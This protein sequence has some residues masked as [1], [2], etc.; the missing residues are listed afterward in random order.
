MIVYGT[1]GAGKA[2][3]ASLPA[4]QINAGTAHWDGAQW[5]PPASE[6]VMPFAKAEPKQAFLKVGIYGPQ[7]SGKTFT[8]LLMAEGIAKKEK[9]RIAYV[10]TERGTD[11]YVQKVKS[12][13]VHPDKF[14]VDT[15]YSKSLAEIWKDVQSLDPKKHSVVVLDSISHLWDSAIEAYTG[16]KT[17]HGS[18][19]MHAWGNIKRP[20][21]T[22]LSWLLHSPFHIFILGR[23]KNVFE[24]DD[25]GQMKKVGVAMRAEGETP[26]EP[27]ICLRT[28]AVRDPSD[29][30]KTRHCLYVEKDRTGVLSGVLWDPGFHTLEPI[31]PLLHG[32]QAG[33]ED[34]D[35]R[36]AADAELMEEM[37]SKKRDKEE[38]SRGI[39]QEFQS[40]IAGA[41][42]LSALGAIGKEIKKKKRYMI[43][44]HANALRQLFASVRERFVEA[45]APDAV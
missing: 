13:R 37:E 15:L 8:T 20:Y 39:F 11:F 36:I 44:D 3:T 28:E 16:R 21:K 17:K 34:E 10:D 6:K 30:T 26:Y 31:L 19:P 9:K 23:Q 27:H 45:E 5:N 29:S 7:G 41:N 14:D 35:E 25:Q 42:D 43:E 4:E 18:I 40:Q 32:E 38:K 33:L 22:L 12:R 1:K 2:T 24:D